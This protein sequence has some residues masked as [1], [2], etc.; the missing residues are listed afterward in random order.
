MGVGPILPWRRTSRRS[1]RNW[2][3]WPVLAGAAVIV[4]LFASG[5]DQWVAVIAFGIVAFVGT[6]IAEEW[7][8]GTLARRRSGDSWPVAYWKL[9][10][11]NRPRHGGYIVHLAILTLAIG[12]IGTQFFDQRVDVA[13]LPGQSAIIDDYRVEFID[14]GQSN[15]IDR[16][17]VWANLNL[18]RIDR[19]MYDA[20]PEGYALGPNRFD[21]AGN[22]YDGDR[23]IGTLEPWQAFYPAFNQVSVRSGIRSTPVEDLYLIPSN[24]NDDGSIALR[25]SIN[26]LAMWLWIAGPIFLLGTTVALW[27]APAVERLTAPV[28]RR[29]QRET[30]P[31]GA[32]GDA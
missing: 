11:G 26:P 3:V 25:M 10:N 27:P 21:M 20:D 12:I 13:I 15:R 16:T 29:Q 17:A 23:F 14:T 9:V 32:S 28:S 18:Y 2:F 4:G 24:F 5:I 1:L 7:W 8:R 30:V 6:A 22:S 19:A 31:S